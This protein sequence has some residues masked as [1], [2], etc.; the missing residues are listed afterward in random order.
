MPLDLDTLKT[1]LGITDNSQ[2]AALTAVA[3]EAQALCE[4]YC[5]RKFDKAA[6]EETFDQTSGALLVRRWPIDKAAGVAIE[7]AAGRPVPTTNYRVDYARGTI[8]GR[9]V[10][11]APGW[12]FGWS[13][14]TVSYTGG[15]D[16][17]PIALNWAVTQ[18]FDVLWSETPGGGIAAGTIGAAGDVKKYAVVGAFSVEAVAGAAGE[19]GANAGEGWGPLPASITSALDAYRR[20]SAVGVG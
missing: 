19:V 5:D 11:W 20:E 8:K 13:P 1:R 4:D 2:D 10:S 16:P 6:D 7:D 3:A 9:S 12:A 15:F 14:L 18:A 17:W